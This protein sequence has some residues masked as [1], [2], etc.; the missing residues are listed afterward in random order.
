[1]KV[2]IGFESRDPFQVPAFF[3][4][5]RAIQVTF[6]GSLM[7]Q[8]TFGLSVAP[9][10][11]LVGVGGRVSLSSGPARSSWMNEALLIPTILGAWAVWKFWSDAT[12]EAGLC[13]WERKKRLLRK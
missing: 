10:S 9:V 8:G 1:M 2:D 6:I 4:C 7:G 12:A 13:L 5:D 3:C 11:G